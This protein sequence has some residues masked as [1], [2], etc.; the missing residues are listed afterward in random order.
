MRRWTQYLRKLFYG[1]G[2][3]FAFCLLMSCALGG[4]KAEPPPVEYN[5]VGLHQS[6]RQATLVSGTVKY[7]NFSGGEIKVEA[8]RSV[9]CQYGRCPIIGEPA[10][11][12]LRLAA[13]GPYALDLPQSAKDLMVV[14]TLQG[15]DG[16]GRVAHL[17]LV[18]EATQVPEV[19]LSLDRPHP[20]L[21]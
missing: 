2:L 20:P 13:P 14:A 12:E 18:S 17:T 4:D 21:R 6:D 1:L 7:K 15:S 10:V 5:G 16:R 19:D 8:L 11:A 9:P 3:G